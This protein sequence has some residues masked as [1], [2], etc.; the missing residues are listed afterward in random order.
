MSLW[1][2]SVYVDG[3][4]KIKM[5]MGKREESEDCLSSCIQ[6]TWVCVVSQRKN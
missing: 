4:V 1:L 2:F 5:G 3:V 6:M